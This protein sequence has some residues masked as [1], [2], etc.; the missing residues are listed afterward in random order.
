METNESVGG[1]AITYRVERYMNGEWADCG[2]THRSPYGALM[3]LR[4]LDAELPGLYRIADELMPLGRRVTP[5]RF[6]T[7]DYRVGPVFEIEP[8]LDNPAGRTCC[9]C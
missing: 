6:T 9:G 4:A 8:V 3:S 1:L 7:E 5:T 2:V